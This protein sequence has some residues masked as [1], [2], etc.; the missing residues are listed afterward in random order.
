M[1]QATYTHSPDTA[2][3]RMENLALQYLARACY[4]TTHGLTV[5]RRAMSRVRR[6]QSDATKHQAAAACAWLTDRGLLADLQR[7]HNG[8]ATYRVTA[9]GWAKCGQTPPPGV[10]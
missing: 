4:L 2:A 3:R 5:S 6:S 1:T 10:T 8:S 7:E 9:E